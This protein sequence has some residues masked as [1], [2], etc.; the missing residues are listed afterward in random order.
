MA[1]GLLVVD[2]ALRPPT[3]SSTTTPDEDLAEVFPPLLSFRP[4]RNYKCLRKSGDGNEREV[5]SC[6]VLLW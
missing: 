6:V 1:G 3:A 5:G 4:L 2:P